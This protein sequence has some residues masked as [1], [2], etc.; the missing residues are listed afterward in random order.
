MI[1]NFNVLHC[2]I[3]FSLRVCMCSPGKIQRVLVFS[4][5]MERGGERRLRLREW[6]IEEEKIFFACICLFLSPFEMRILISAYVFAGGRGEEGGSQT[7]RER[8]K[9]AERR[10][11][12]TSAV[13]GI[14]LCVATLVHF[15]GRVLSEP[16]SSLFAFP[17]SP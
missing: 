14:L 4:K 15:Q 8:E 11:I 3:F 10:L 16:V 13:S 1:T 7:E 12:W 17:P 6:T 2:M 5:Q 9:G